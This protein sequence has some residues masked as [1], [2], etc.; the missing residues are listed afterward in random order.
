MEMIGTR[1][2]R[3]MGAL[4]A[5]AHTPRRHRRRMHGRDHQHPRRGTVRV[6]RL[7]RGSDPGGVLGPGTWG[8]PSA[9]RGPEF[10]RHTVARSVSMALLDGLAHIRHG[11]GWHQV[12]RSEIH[13]CVGSVF[14]S[15]V[16]PVDQVQQSRLPDDER[17]VDVHGARRQRQG[18]RLHVRGLTIWP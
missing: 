13:R 1:R 14:Q 11:L 7:H 2:S 10:R 6:R 4:L 9:F 8:H 16:P 15:A 12:D 5:G 3:R 18:R 17:E